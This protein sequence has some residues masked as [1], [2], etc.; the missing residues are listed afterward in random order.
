V[1]QITSFND[2]K[3][4]RRIQY[5]WA[6]EDMDN[7][8]ITQQGYQGALSFPRE[9][10]IKDTYGVVHKPA[11]TTPGNSR[12][13]QSSNGSWTAST[14]GVRP[15]S[16]V[17][18]GLRR[19]SQHSKTQCSRRICDNTSQLPLPRKLSNSYE[20]KLVIK[21]TTGATG[22][23][24]AASP[25]REEYTNI[26]YDPSKHSV[27]LDRLHSSQISMFPNTTLAGYFEPYQI[28]GAGTEPIE[29]NI[30][31]DGSLVEVFVNDRFALTGRIYPSRD[32]SHGFA[33]YS[34]PGAHVQYSHI[35][36]WNGLLNVWPQRPLNSSSELIFDTP[37][38]TNNYTWW[39]GN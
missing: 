12:Y 34:A 25:D 2:T 5:G 33:L 23:T 21:D 32:D 3:N 13:I 11:D 15:A 17:V 14:L 8:G 35:E 7:F 30:F 19:G 10:F 24:I 28:D 29:M 31:V 26:Y 38:E 16:D 37:A 4:N 18:E 22:V 20:L 9:L 1:Y 36:I 39:E 27:V 6:S